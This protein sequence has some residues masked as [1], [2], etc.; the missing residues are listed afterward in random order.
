MFELGQR[1]GALSAQ[2]LHPLQVAI[3]KKSTNKPS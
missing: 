2:K 1:E 3:I